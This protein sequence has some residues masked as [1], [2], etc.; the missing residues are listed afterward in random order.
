MFVCLT[1]AGPNQPGQ[2]GAG[3]FIPTM[4]HMQPGGYGFPRGPGGQPGAGPRQPR[5]PNQARPNMAT[6]QPHAGGYA[7][8]QAARQPRPSM[9]AGPRGPSQAGRPVAGGHGQFQPRPPQPM[10]VPGKPVRPAA[11]Q[12]QQ[13]TQMPPGAA[14]NQPRQVRNPRTLSQLPSSPSW[15]ACQWLTESNSSGRLTQC[16]ESF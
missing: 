12:Y 9:Q 14:A 15:L 8:P 1:I 4:P 3:Y 6:G 11:A 7:G 2:A 5:W 10:Q 16:D 13:R